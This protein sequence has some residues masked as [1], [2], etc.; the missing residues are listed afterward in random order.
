M[1]EYLYHCFYCGDKW[2]GIYRVNDPVCR[3]CGSE[4]DY[5]VKVRKAEVGQDVFGYNLKEEVKRYGK[6][7]RH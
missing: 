3:K 1:T 4:G 7:E 2:T 6:K 5:Y